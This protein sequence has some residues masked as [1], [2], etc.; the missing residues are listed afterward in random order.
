MCFT[1]TIRQTPNGLVQ[2]RLLPARPIPANQTSSIQT[3]VPANQV[4]SSKPPTATKDASYTD[5]FA[6]LSLSSV[7]TSDGNDRSANANVQ[8][9]AK[10]PVKQQAAKK[11]Q[12]ATP[13][14][15]VKEQEKEAEPAPKPNKSVPL[16]V[17][18]KSN[19]ASVT[20]RRVPQTLKKAVSFSDHLNR[21]PGR[22][23]TPP[24]D[25]K[26][27]RFAPALVRG[28]G[29]GYSDL[30]PR[31][32]EAYPFDRSTTYTIGLSEDPSPKPP[33][34][35]SKPTLGKSAST[36]HS[37]SANMCVKDRSETRNRQVDFD[38]AS[39]SDDSFTDL[40]I[41]IARTDVN[42]SPRPDPDLKYYRHSSSISSS[43]NISSAFS[44]SLH[45]KFS[46]GQY[47]LQSEVG[48][49]D[50]YIAAA[51][52]ENT[53]RNSLSEASA[54]QGKFDRHVWMGTATAPVFDRYGHRLRTNS[55]GSSIFDQSI[56]RS[57]PQPV[58][59]W[60]GKNPPSVPG[61][62]NPVFALRNDSNSG[63]PVTAMS[64]K[65]QAKRRHQPPSVVDDELDHAVYV[66]PQSKITYRDV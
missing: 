14:V 24:V 10:V 56:R 61:R 54:N 7:S 59:V 45:G 58:F 21:G 34:R 2:E 64:T 65:Q 47:G 31:E 40:V 6:E 35:D 25:E 18:Y 51:T 29:S 5:P 42:A 23:Y 39:D 53:R 17:T 41:P 20:D 66:N 49:D 11:S 50:S 44:R 8:S 1:V 15:Q 33:H 37:Q 9:K 48:D 62:Q 22:S 63:E 13:S 16:P 52:T 4:S 46:S 36:K 55:V 57:W 26:A 30:S 12:P 3:S 38:I 60:R 43:K 19:S 28:Q 32:S 27:V